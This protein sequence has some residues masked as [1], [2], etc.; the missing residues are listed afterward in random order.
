MTRVVW[1]QQGE[2]LYEDGLDRGI[3]FPKVGTGV[4]WNGLISVEEA[5][6]GG[7]VENYYYDGI[8][9]LDF[10]AN[11]DF[12]ATLTAFAAPFEF[13]VC[14]GTK[15]IA[16]GLSVT[17]QPRATFGLS[18]RTGLGND[19]LAEDYGYKLHIVYNCTAAPASRSRRT[20]GESPE[21]TE[22]SWTI[23]TVPPVATTFKP[24]AHF[25]INS[26]RTTP[27]KMAALEDF[28]Y[29]TSTTAPALPTQA[30]VFAL[31]V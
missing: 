7:E 9:Y 17:H 3:L 25:V 21:P 26:K 11:E 14:D 28:L 27:A 4:P 6:D 30:Q 8:K 16:P 22:L 1:G 13:G 19:V 20:R 23:A 18:Y 12:T 31:L 29:G 5:Q 24:T 15:E 2:K 10:V